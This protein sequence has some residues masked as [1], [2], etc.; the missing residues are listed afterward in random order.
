MLRS[1]RRQQSAEVRPRHDLAG[2]PH[3]L[4]PDTLATYS[5]E[6]ARYVDFATRL[7]YV[8]VPGRDAPWN[9]FLLWIYMLHRSEKCK[10]TTIFACLSALAHFGHH[11]RH[12]LATRK[13][14]GDGMMHR[15]IAKMK[16][17]I[18]L[19]YCSSKGI[20]SLTYD[21]QHSVPL[22]R[23]TIELLLSAF[24]VVDEA[25][26]R[27]VRRKDRHHL[28][29]SAMQH[30]AAMRFGHFVARDYTVL[31]FVR[32]ADG[33]YRLITDWHRY[34]GQRKYVLVFS[35][36]PRWPCLRYRVYGGDLS[37]QA[38]LTAADLLDWHF[39]MLREE[40]EVFV[41]RPQKGRQPTR[42]ERREWLVNTLLA[43]LP[44]DERDARKLVADVTPH[45]FRS[46]LAGD[47][48]DAE[49]SWRAIAMRCR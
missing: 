42:A 22:A 46:G 34:Q 30:T 4:R 47:L 6:F 26:F 13:E 44:L 41:F 2:L 43:A 9:M 45:A 37:V 38:Q 19:Y 1:A 27:R 18:S 17:E 36:N 32:G 29:A 33:A 5:A 20:K 7:G 25:S 39:R 40:N 15:D 16:R 10:P 14:D 8:P 24:R 35:R 31:S 11:H 49:A 48:V 12:L 3:G 23:A 21:V 28:V